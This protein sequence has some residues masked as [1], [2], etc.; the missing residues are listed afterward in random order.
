[1]RAG[2]FLAAEIGLKELEAL[3]D[4]PG[5][6]PSRSLQDLR[7]GVKSNSAGVLY[8]GPSPRTFR[9]LDIGP[10]AL[11]SPGLSGSNT[12]KVGP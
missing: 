7:G 1:M 10:G 9:P 4:G 2:E 5:L 8:D 12:V 11:G 3:E 6:V